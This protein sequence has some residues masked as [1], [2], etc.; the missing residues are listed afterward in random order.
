MNE[1]GYQTSVDEMQE[2]FAGIAAHPDY[3]TIVAVL[4]NEVVGMAGLVRG[5]YYEKNGAYLRVVA[6][7]VKSS[8]RDQGIGKLL[9][10]AAEK[11]AIGQG[12]NTVLI[13]CGTREE[14]KASHAFYEKMGYTV[15]SLGFIK[16]MESQ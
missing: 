9:L 14:R 13:N 12:L 7:V 8:R 11:W 1:L 5:I 3:K 16:K 4:N 6:L 2:R 15:K 10:D